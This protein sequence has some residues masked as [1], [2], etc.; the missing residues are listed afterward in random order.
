MYYF[1]TSVLLYYSLLCVVK[2][3]VAGK[4]EET[5]VWDGSVL[6]GPWADVT[7]K[8]INYQMPQKMVILTMVNR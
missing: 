4:R 3:S 2:L 7:M 1:C 5:R 8:M 6:S